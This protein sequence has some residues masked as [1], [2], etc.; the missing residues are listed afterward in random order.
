MVPNSSPELQLQRLMKRDKCSREDAISRLESQLPIGEKIK[1]ADLVIE[2][3]GSLQDLEEQ[4][5]SFLAKV[6]RETGWFWW[7][8]NWLIPP[9]G[10]LSAL[11]TLGWRAVWR[12]WQGTRNNDTGRTRRPSN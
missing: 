2:N 3:S 4:V 7:R 5:N 8:L 1:Y 10:V 11:S 9:I 12:P 6:E